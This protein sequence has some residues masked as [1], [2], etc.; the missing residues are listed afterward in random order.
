M[1]TSEPVVDYQTYQAKSR[2]YPLSTFQRFREYGVRALALADAMK[3][4]KSL[5]FKY[6]ILIAQFGNKAFQRCVA[7]HSTTKTRVSAEI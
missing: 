4:K 1:Q 2:N 3:L 6:F 7:R 5:F